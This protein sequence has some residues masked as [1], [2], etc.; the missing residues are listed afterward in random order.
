MNSNELNTK[1]KYNITLDHHDAL[2]DASACAELFNLHLAT[3]IR[4]FFA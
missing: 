3:T 1:L 2:S 4:N